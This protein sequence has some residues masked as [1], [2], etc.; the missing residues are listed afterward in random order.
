MSYGQADP[1]DSG[2]RRYIAATME[3]PFLEREHEFKLARRWRDE[4]DAEALHELV[5]SYA[6][7]VVKIA[8]GFRGY[9]LPLGDL[10]QEG[11]IGLMEAAARFDPDRNVRFS[12]YAAWWV[13]AAIQEHILRNASIVRIGTTASQKRLF[14]NLRRLRARL[15]ENPDGPMTDADRR[16]IAD[17]LAVPIAAVERMESHLSRPD[18][19]LNATLGSN[20]TDEIQDFLTDS[21]PTPEDIAI[22]RCDRLT[23]ADWIGEALAQLTPRERRIVASRFLEDRPMTLAELGG[24]FGVSKERIRQIEAKAI[25]KLRATIGE[26]AG[27]AIKLP[28]G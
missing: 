16:R 13:V 24:V 4:G 18:Q 2:S 27:D 3:A 22:E 5:F 10:V 20:E 19:S 14:F 11:N 8:A 28:D 26:I 12:T 6:R 9:G 7:F 17:E 1:I 25:D 23:R 21:G 15:A